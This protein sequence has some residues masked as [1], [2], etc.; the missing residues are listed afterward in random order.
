M[1]TLVMDPQPAE[2]EALLERRRQLGLDHR[3]EVWEGVYRMMPPPTH[4]HGLL[5]IQ[6]ACLLRPCADS[7]GLGLTNGV[8]IGEP[9]VNYRTPDLALH[10][11]DA[12]PMWHP[13]AALAVEV[14][15]PSD[16]SLAKLPFYAAH[17]V[18]EVLIVDPATHSVDWLGLNDGEYRPIEHSGLIDLGV[19][20]LAERIDWPPTE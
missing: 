7:A 4:N 3:D 16:E 9:D 8:A 13:T 19:S 14:V 5:V 20:D 12:A 15:S 1:A 17:D 18:D 11:A 10:R 6:L 2:F